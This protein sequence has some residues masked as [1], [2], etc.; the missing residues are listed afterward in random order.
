MD[1]IT[2]NKLA[3]WAIVILIIL[4]I[5]TLSLVLFKGGPPRPDERFIREMDDAP[6]PDV[7]MFLEKELEFSEQQTKTLQFLRQ[8]HFKESGTLL[9][10]IH[11]LKK[12]ILS[13]L[14]NEKPDPEKVK[15]AADEIGKLQTEFELMIYNHFGDIKN[16]CDK[17]QKIR[18]A[19]LLDEL[20]EKNVA[21]RE[22]RIKKEIRIIHK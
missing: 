2:K 11:L 12:E 9:D 17:E 15:P 10:S 22:R 20:I 8:T 4:N 5:A 3:F 19:N 21:P 16:V 13:D 14:K 18:F 6:P 7:L 1:F